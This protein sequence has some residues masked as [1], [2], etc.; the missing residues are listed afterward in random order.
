MHV[1]CSQQ[2]FW[3]ITSEIIPKAKSEFRGPFYK[4]T[5]VV[6]KVLYF[7]QFL[8]MSLK[9]ILGLITGLHVPVIAKNFTVDFALLMLG[10]YKLNNMEL[11]RGQLKTCSFLSVSTLRT[12]RSALVCKPRESSYRQLLLL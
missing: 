10:N 3:C 6:G 2:L 11:G 1:A 9:H 7:L 5:V 4:G 12:F 8:F